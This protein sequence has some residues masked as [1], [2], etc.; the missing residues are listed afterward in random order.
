[1][2]AHVFLQAEAGLACINIGM[3]VHLSSS[4]HSL[5]HLLVCAV[6]KSCF[7]LRSKRDQR[8]DLPAA[9]PASPHSLGCSPRYGFLP[10][11]PAFPESTVSILGKAGNALWPEFISCP[12]SGPCPRLFGEDLH[13]ILHSPSP[14]ESLLIPPSGHLRSCPQPDR[15]T[16]RRRHSGQ[17]SVYGF[18][19]VFFLR[20]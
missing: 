15:D 5:L 20:G 9:H 4:V 7:S 11:T 2:Y 10:N 19:W 8:W 1:M 6:S 16:E 12:L 14:K 13:F 17:G 3:P 18:R